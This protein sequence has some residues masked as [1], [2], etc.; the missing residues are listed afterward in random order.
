MSQ[1]SQ[2]MHSYFRN[3]LQQTSG[4]KFKKLKGKFSKEDE[5]KIRSELSRT[6]PRT[7]QD[8]LDGYEYRGEGVEEQWRLD[9]LEKIMKEALDRAEA[10][11]SPTLS[12]SRTQ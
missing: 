7:V 5:D 9:G 6:D 11:T 4:D 3:S 2:H 12:L 1:L 10:T 8:I